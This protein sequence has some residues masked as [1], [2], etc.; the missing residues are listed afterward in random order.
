MTFKTVAT[1]EPGNFFFCFFVFP[2]DS[3]F[4]RT[5]SATVNSR[6]AHK[7][8]GNFCAVASFYAVPARACMNFLRKMRVKFFSITM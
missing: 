3:V 8:Q 7:G 4:A 1:S 2:A 6:T 5:A